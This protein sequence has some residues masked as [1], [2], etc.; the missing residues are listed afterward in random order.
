MTRVKIIY[1]SDEY[2][3]KLGQLLTDESSRKI[4]SAIAKKEL[5]T[6][7]IAKATGLGVSLVIYHLN[8]MKELE[9]IDTVEKPIRVRKTKD[10]KYYK[11][12]TD[13]MLSITRGP[14]KK[15]RIKSIFKEGVK[16]ACIGMAAFGVWTY[17]KTQTVV[18]NSINDG[19]IAPDIPIIVPE[20]YQEGMFF[21]ML[22]IILGLVGNTIYNH[23]KK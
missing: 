20:F 16:F 7:E 22:V 3:S 8:K 12:R 15:D 17:T 4:M 9:L 14:E 11:I 5:Y 1:M 2:L 23:L 13:I 21:P 6:S 10:H 19:G 18:K